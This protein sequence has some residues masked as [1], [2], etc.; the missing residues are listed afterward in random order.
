[1]EIEKDIILEVEGITKE[2]PG[3]TALDNMHF[4]LK[5]GEIHAIVGENGAGK[6]TLMHI[7][8]GIYK[9]N[10]GNI[11][12]ENKK[13]K[14]NNPVDATKAGIGI[15]FQELSLVRDLSV[16]ENIFANRQPINR[17]NFIKFSS[18]YKEAEKMLD[19]FN[20]DIDPRTPVKYLSIDKRQLVEI[21]K[22]MSSN[23]KILI[24][25]EPTS[26][27]SASEIERLFINIE[28][29][30]SK[31]ISIIYISH[32]LQEIFKIADRVTILKD[33]KYVDTLE[34]SKVD[35]KKLVNLMVG[36]EISHKYEKRGNIDRKNIL[37]KVDKLNH[38]KFYKDISFE[39]YKGEIVGF[40]GLVGS[41]RTE[42][43]KSIF[44]VL[45]FQSGK[46]YLEGQDIKIKSPI[47]AMEKGIAY[48][49]EDRKEEGLFLGMDICANSI[50]PQ[51]KKFSQGKA[52]GILNEQELTNYT[53]ELIK[54]FHVSTPSIR[55]IIRNLSGGNQ[56][57]VLLSMWLGMNPKVVIVDEPT[58]GI[59]VGARSEI[60]NIL[61]QLAS[62]GVGVIV[63]SSELVDI[64]S[65]SDRILV[66]RTGE[67]VAS[68][69]NDEAN[70]K[71]IIE[72]ATGVRK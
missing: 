61:R 1:M 14:L 53:S 36:R 10:S 13:V 34:V 48:T 56:Q 41:G 57:K 52:F 38:D 4:K 16:A 27:L 12:I 43:A 33:G 26:S 44:G 8:G 25:D 5:K 71:N 31:G 62:T 40:A 67:L 6:S 18:M 65:I 37:L 17:V 30:K 11:Y 21:L 49:S 20:E 23:P 2:F 19:T 70:E 66:M 28:T 32:H 59:D 72:Y 42:L 46:F 29:L 60:Y 9:P 69:N 51:L 39:L 68:L 47:D 63:I 54:K 22:A 35:E 50:V 64:L 55:Q 15:V 7:L 45:K 24:L 3:V 58:K